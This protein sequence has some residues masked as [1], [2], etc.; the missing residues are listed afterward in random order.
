MGPT[1]VGWTLEVAAW[2]PTTG[3]CDDV[4]L[5]VAGAF[6]VAV[7]ACGF[8]GRE[9]ETRPTAQRCEL[10]RCERCSELAGHGHLGRPGTRFVGRWLCSVCWRRWTHNIECGRSCEAKVAA[11]STPQPRARSAFELSE[12]LMCCRD[13]GAHTRLRV[14][15]DASSTVGSSGDFICA[16]C[17]LCCCWAEDPHDV[18]WMEGGIDLLR[19]VA[20]LRAVAGAAAEDNVWRCDARSADVQRTRFEDEISPPEEKHVLPERIGDQPWPHERIDVIWDALDLKASRLARLLYNE[21]GAFLQFAELHNEGDV[22]RAFAGHPGVPQDQV[23]RERGLS[24]I[25]PEGIFINGCEDHPRVLLYELRYLLTIAPPDPQEVALFNHKVLDELSRICGW[26][27]APYDARPHVGE[28]AVDGA[29]PAT[30]LC[31]PTLAGGLQ[32]RWWADDNALALVSHSLTK[33]KFCILDNFL[34]ANELKK[35]QRTALSL[36]HSG[37]L[38]RG[39]TEQRQG[40]GSYFGE[41]S[42]NEGDFLNIADVPRKWTV[43]GDRRLWL[44][45][46]DERADTSLR[47]LSQALDELI[48]SM[49]CSEVTA[50]ETLVRLNRIDFREDT[51]VACYSGETRARYMKH[52]DTTGRKA[53]LTTIVYLNDEWCPEADGGCLRLYDDRCPTRVRYDVAPYANRL[54]LFW[55]TDECPHEVRAATRDR[56]AMTTWFLDGRQRIGTE[57]NESCGDVDHLTG[58]LRNANVFASDCDDDESILQLPPEVLKGMGEDQL[59]MARK[60]RVV[61]ARQLRAEQAA[62]DRGCA[63]CGAEALDAVTATGKRLS[64]AGATLSR[65]A[66]NAAAGGK[67]M[68]SALGL[69][70]AGRLGASQFEDDWFC[71][72]CWASWDE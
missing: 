54:L 69:N 58:I 22:A 63:G 68:L 50:P 5:A 21:F 31:L 37:Q 34:S 35:L 39:L 26:H 59:D 7:V 19:E 16:A 52:C 3:V 41:E 71:D 29:A 8:P 42:A 24:A 72:R 70:I 47:I 44:K 12:T 20:R 40:E 23:A 66:A 15:I 55:A 9:A 65:T 67:F 62:K 30:E 61:F 56:Y 45:D 18:A 48:H 17:W 2:H 51:M 36:H 1:I 64:P 14:R 27:A 25:L 11:V 43:Q 6:G 10:R 49:R 53:V 13:C 57:G 28:G 32:H 33:H 60:F 38:A 46:S 4:L